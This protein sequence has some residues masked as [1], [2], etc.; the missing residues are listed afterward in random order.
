M[1]DGRDHEHPPA[2]SPTFLG[3]PAAWRAAARSA[4]SAAGTG[5]VPLPQHRPRWPLVVIAILVQL[6]GFAFAAGHPFL[7]A[8]YLLAVLSSFL[9]LA[10]RRFPGPVVTAVAVLCSPAIAFGFGPPLSAVPL[11]IAVFLA[12]LHGAR[13]WAWG[14]LVGLA[15]AGPSA[16]ALVRSARALTGS[17][18]SVVRPLAVMLVLSLLVG[19]AEMQRGRRE[20]YREMAR[21][22]AAQR[23]AEAEAERTRIA[24]ELHDVLAHSLSQISVQAGVGLHLFDTQPDRAKESLDAIKKTSSDALDEVRG[25]LGFLRED[26]SQGLRTPGPGLDRLPGLISS[27][28]DLGLTVQVYDDLGPDVR[29]SAQLAIYRIVQESLTNVARHAPGASA[30]VRLGRQGGQYEITVTD[31][32]PGPAGGYRPGRGMVGMRERAQLLRGSFEAGPRAEGGFRV[33]ARIPVGAGDP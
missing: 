22:I 30:D 31:D 6:P 4:H 16:V 1:T 5:A 18:A 3:G 8:V 32:G 24:R 21:R 13:P 26:S 7:H 9:L 15:I 14:T 2:T 25:V 19:F 27:F 10:S 28:R 17:P 20:R 11:A 23:Q 12:I 33:H 29:H